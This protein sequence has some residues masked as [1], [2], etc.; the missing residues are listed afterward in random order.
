MEAAGT[1]CEGLCVR[2]PVLIE[3][4]LHADTA[5][6]SMHLSAFLRATCLTLPSFTHRPPTHTMRVCAACLLTHLLAC[7]LTDTGCGARRPPRGIPSSSCG[8]QVPVVVGPAC[9]SRCCCHTAAAG[10]TC[11]CARPATGTGAAGCRRQRTGPFVVGV[12]MSL[13]DVLFV[14]VVVLCV[15]VL[16]LRSLCGMASYLTRQYQHQPTYL[17]PTPSHTHQLTRTPNTQ[18]CLYDVRRMSNSSIVN[19]GSSRASQQ[20]L[21]THNLRARAQAAGFASTSS[22]SSSVAAAA[23]LSYG[24]ATLD[25]QFLCDVVVNPT[26]PNLAAYIRPQLQVR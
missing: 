15:Q 24:V 22:G 1:V 21:M 25:S 20:L 19:F 10:A 4:R 2:V 6:D 14:C 3:H 13:G 17:P 26:D 7:S 8:R 23:S 12:W 18:V 5:T 9:W 11:S 16:Q